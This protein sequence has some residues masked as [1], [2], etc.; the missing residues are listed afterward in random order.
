MISDKV[1]SLIRDIYRENLVKIFVKIE[2]KL[3]LIR[4]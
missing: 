1:S 4:I 2:K 3:K